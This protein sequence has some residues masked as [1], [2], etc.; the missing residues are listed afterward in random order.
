MRTFTLNVVAI[1]MLSMISAVQ[2]QSATE[3]NKVTVSGEGDKLGAGLLMDEDAPKARSS[4]TKAQLEKTRSSGNPFQALS[5]LPGVN[6]TSNDATGLFG[7]GL[8]VRGFNSDQMGFTV[9]GAPVNDSGNFAVFPQEYVD[10]ENLCS[11]YITQ[12]APDTD[13]P[14]VGAVGGNVGIQSCAPEDV[15][16]VRIAL[17]GGQLGYFRTFARVDTGKVG[18]F[19][20]FM[21]ASLSKANK[22]KGPGRADRKHIDLG[23]EYDLGSGNKLSASVLYNRAVNNNFATFNQTQWAANGYNADYIPTPPQHQTPV[24]GTRQVDPNPSPQYFGYALNPFENYLVTAKANIT[25]T[26]RLRLEVVPYLWR[27]YG[28]GG[29]QQNVLNESTS[30]TSVHGGIG[31]I[32]GDGDR[33]DS[34]LVY[35]G[36]LTNTYRPGVTTTLTYVLDQHKI[37]GGVWYER[38][39]HRQTQPAVRVSNNGGIADLWLGSNLVQYTDGTNY[40]GRDWSTISTGE[41]VFV[42]DTID[43]LDNKLQVTPAFSYRRLNRQFANYGNSGANAAA[44]YNVDQSYGKG[45]PSLAISYQATDRLQAFTSIAK[46]FRTPS[47]FEYGNV[48]KGQTI[49]GGVGSVT[50]LQALT[51]KPE[52]S[53]NL[54]VGAR[55]KGDMFRGSATAFYNKFKDR[56]ASSFDPLEGISRDIN[57]GSSTTKGLEIEAGTIP[58]NGLSGYASLTYTKSTI[59]ENVISRLLTPAGA[60]CTTPSATCAPVPYATAGKIFPDTPK[61]LA[62]L[63]VQYAEGPYLLNI[64]AKYT[65]GRFLTLTNDTALKGYTLFDL[66]AAWK[67]PNPS[68]PGFKNPIIRLNVSNLLNKQYFM[69]NAGSGSNVTVV[70][71]G[72][73]GA[74]FY[75][76]GAPRFTSLTFQVDY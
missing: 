16:R 39:R 30:S 48:G 70:N 72:A 15:Q 75:Y 24:A 3:L 29:V 22:W 58:W 47:N 28:T 19:K 10:Q 57:V 42:Q 32:N 38:A 25:L 67:L 63:S 41:S 61:G 6:S 56:I 1:A 11:L 66:N 76:A 12:G 40:Q 55:Y 46:N 14:H 71:G 53:V 20:A 31:D 4:V 21:S 59:D 43:L 17:S 51:I 64:G 44:S 23:A 74:P 27:G 18:D 33:L 37:S 13:A 26:D 7:G 49:V 50:G 45:L 34:V 65:S 5:L 73:A 9:N 54:D 36:S 8:R 35:R 68:G 69:A 2:A 62:G 60:A 52:Q